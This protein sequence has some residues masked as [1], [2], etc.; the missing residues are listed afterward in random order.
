MT[1]Q[2]TLQRAVSGGWLLAGALLLLLIS[3]PA[4]AN[5]AA[6]VHFAS[7]YVAA[8]A[9]G[10]D[11]RQL[12][13]GDDIFRTERVDTGDN[14]RV[15]MRFTDGGLVSLMPGS[16]FTI[17]EYFHEGGADD[18]ASLVFGLLRGGL[19]TV[20]GTIGKTKH[21]QYELRTPVAT[22][23]IRGTEYIAV[24][25]P[26]N[27]LRVHVGRGKV[28]ITNDHG[29]LEVA[30]GQNAV[31]TLGS[32]PEFSD[33]APQ[34]QATS[35]MGD[36]LIAQ[37]QPKQDPHMLDPFAN[38]PGTGREHIVGL[39]QQ[40]EPSTLPLQYNQMVATL[41]FGSNG[42][43]PTGWD[44]L[45]VNPDA[46][47]K[48]VSTDLSQLDTSNWQ[49]FSVGSH[50]SVS[51]GE[52][53]G[54]TG[55]VHGTLIDLSDPL[56]MPYVIGSGPDVVPTSGSLSYSLAGSTPVRGYTNDG[57][58]VSTGTLNHFNLDIGFVSSGIASI[59][60]GMELSLPGHGPLGF[61]ART[62]SANNESAQNLQTGGPMFSFDGPVM[63]DG[64]ACTS[65]SP[66]RIEVGGML[67]G[68]NA[69]EA[70]IV[71]T[72]SENNETAHGAAGL[73]TP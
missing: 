50:G 57:V 9:P 49:V 24:I 25:R 71:Y 70:G 64:N 65:S 72:I 43:G 20:T 68:T 73:T 21:E 30:E 56:Y 8:T 14:G 29:T 59:T 60:Y 52:M 4:H 63:R 42:F 10:Q 7:G 28:V 23:G 31:V 33:Q 44:D 2:Q 39:P 18:D 15:Q 61:A 11:A 37:N 6:N 32:A 17:D 5:L 38:M 45:E 40:S 16:T 35:P 12:A 19:R 1:L 55:M 36:R 48:P 62:Y 22:L 41:P 46:T 47:G 54:T 51:W 66:C 67:S 3:A 34:Y 13:K 26:A 27:T 58:F 53:T 69:T